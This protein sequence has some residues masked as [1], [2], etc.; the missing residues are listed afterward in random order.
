MI[1]KH[2][3]TKLNG[4]KYCYVSLT[5]QLKIS[6]LFTQ[7][8]DQTVLVLTIQFSIS[9]FFACYILTLNWAVN[10]EMHLCKLAKEEWKQV[11]VMKEYKQGA[12][13]CRSIETGMP[14]WEPACRLRALR[15]S[16]THGWATPAK[17]R[18]SAAMVKR[19]T[20]VN[21]AVHLC[22]H[23]SLTYNRTSPFRK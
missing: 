23:S 5:I 6:H 2:K 4:S 13:G 9:H 10:Q 20:W 21:I 7:S 12:D 16:V 8:N 1:C 19:R 18:N 14:V 11:D 3:S 17:I 22:L 15:P